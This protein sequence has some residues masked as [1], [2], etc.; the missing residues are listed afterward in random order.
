MNKAY[1]FSLN[2]LKY[3]EKL[4]ARFKKH[5]FSFERWPEVYWGDFEVDGL[6]MEKYSGDWNI[7]FNPDYLGVYKYGNEGIIILNRK[8]ILECV[9][10]ISPDLQHLTK[11]EILEA[12]KFKVLMHE[13]GHWLTHWCCDD[14][15]NVG[16]FKNLDDVVIETMAQL[17]V[18]WALGKYSNPFVQS[19]RDVFDFI[20]PLQ[21]YPYQAFKAFGKNS[22][23][24]GTILRR[25]NKVL[26]GDEK[27]I[28]LFKDADKNDLR[29]RN[30]LRQF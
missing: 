2:E 27:E 10:K 30:C 16:N 1:R 5:G 20:V 21:P 15:V 6:F 13:I 14:N 19:V 29:L 17:S 24:I 23:K 4:Q 25:Y 11:N 18:E 9:N 26:D 22:S 7:I 3:M 28:H 8:N 12:L